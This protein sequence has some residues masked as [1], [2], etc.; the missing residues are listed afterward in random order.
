M[1]R[2]LWA[3]VFGLACG[4]R[5]QAQQTMTPEMKARIDASVNDVMQKTGVPSAEVGV[6][7]DGRIAYTA[8]FGKARLNPELRA[9]VSMHYPVGS[10]SKQFTAAGVLLLV[11]DGKMNL[12][13]P[14][15]KW[16][17]ELTRAKDVTVRMLLSHTSGYS[18]YAPQDYTI[19]AWTKPTDPLKLVHDWAEKPL[20]FE[21]GTKWQYSNTNFVLA[22]LIIE[23]VSGQP[24]WAFLKS[25]VL[26]PLGLKEALNLDT[27]RARVEPQGT[28]RHA[29]GPL[30]PAT[31]EAPGWYFGDASLAMPVEDLL[32]WDISII[33]RGLLK[34][35]S[36]KA[37]E[38][39]V[40]LKNGAPTGYGLAVDVAVKNGSRVISHSGEVGGFVAD[41]VVLPDDHTAIAVLT[42]QEASGAAAQ[43]AAAIGAIV[44]NPVVSNGTSPAE[45][46]VRSMLN[47]LEDGKLD[48]SALTQDCSY[49][50]SQQ[51][52]EDFANS[53][54]PLGPAV[55]VKQTREA[56]R[57]GMAFRAFSASLKSGKTLN[58]STYWMPDGRIE[59]FLVEAA[60]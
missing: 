60:E 16:F 22:A 8:A 25:R 41:N 55:E 6:V 9:T 19:P 37:M 30:R 59:Q 38:T 47:A 14:V 1:D 43:I 48:R 29:L 46:Q 51:T 15:A 2:F 18:D 5:L 58:V 11:Q 17:P 20:D 52:M 4:G 33:D 23:K 31:L 39:E 27:D 36:Y 49:Y 53:L 56:L 12:D 54:K 34:P 40:L 21:P 13:D 32:K 24:Y 50:F 7:L 35:E 28:E 42:N 57:G 44:R 26:E 3:L 45:A 10:I